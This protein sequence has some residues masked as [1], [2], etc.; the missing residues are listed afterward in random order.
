V[1]RT[2]PRKYIKR[3]LF[4]TIYEVEHITGWSIL[5]LSGEFITKLRVKENRGSKSVSFKLLNSDVMSD[6]DGWWKL[7]PCTQAGLN[8]LYGQDGSPF[9]G[10]IG[11]SSFP[12]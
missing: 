3:G 2:N 8:R 9:D 11:M 12:T 5:W 1:Q 7:Q 10:I 4:E 6:F